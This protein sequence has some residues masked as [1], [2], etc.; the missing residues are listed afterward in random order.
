MC[1][2]AYI[3]ILYTSKLPRT[4]DFI[5]PLSGFFEAERVF[6]GEEVSHAFVKNVLKEGVEQ[7]NHALS[8]VR[9]TE[10]E[11]LLKSLNKDAGEVEDQVEHVK[12]VLD[13]ILRP[14]CLKPSDSGFLTL[15]FH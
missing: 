7:W 5:S 1:R 2:Y 15:C 8:V 10:P 6:L 12:S 4:Y 14:I 13:G 11:V 3:F 9:D